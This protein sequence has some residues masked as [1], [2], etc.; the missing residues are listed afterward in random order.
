MKNYY[1]ILGVKSDASADEIK[2]AYRGLAK[3]YHPDRNKDD[4]DAIA[5]FQDA[6]EAYEVLGNDAEREKYDQKLA[7]QGGNTSNT[8]N[9]F[10]SRNG[11]RRTNSK[12]DATC[13]EDHFQN[14]NRQ[15]ESFFGFSASG[16][17]VDKDKLGKKK[18]PLDTSDIFESFFRKK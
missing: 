1:E 12:K 8:S 18:N 9:G 16:G 17:V 15:F 5:K 7:N 13:T 2:R 10:N 11:Q 3:K 6:S 4:K 14:L